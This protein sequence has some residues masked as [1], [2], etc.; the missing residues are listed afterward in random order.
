MGAYDP[1]YAHEY[2]M[3]HRQLKGRGKSS[4]TQAKTYR[5]ASTSG[6][7]LSSEQRAQL[8]ETWEGLKEE[9]SA[10][11][12]EIA[13]AKKAAI[14]ALNESIKAK[15]ERFKR[16]L[17]LSKEQYKAGGG[18]S[19]A[20]YENMKASVK[21]EIAKLREQKA[22]GREAIK[23]AA[24]NDLEKA[25]EKCYNSYQNAVD[26]AARS[27]QGGKKSSSKKSANSDSKTARMNQIKAAA[28]AKRKR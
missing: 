4:S 17:E 19:K 5:K 10:E 1:Q 3:K 24:K 15:I 9:L 26:A 2:Y 12:D 8:K 25:K 11:R 6:L 13:E 7:G 23:K 18:V 22:V 21:G 14:E 27:P 28:M 20:Q 16:Q